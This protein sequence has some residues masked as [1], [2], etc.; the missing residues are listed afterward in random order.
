MA[1]TVYK[2]TRIFN[3][4]ELSSKI[5]D[6]KEKAIEN[7]KDEEFIISLDMSYSDFYRVNQNIENQYYDVT[8]YEGDKECNAIIKLEEINNE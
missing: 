3:R 5:Y 7:Y 8:Y 1:K 6:N 2:F 4:E